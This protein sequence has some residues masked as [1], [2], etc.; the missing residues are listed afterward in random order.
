M[1]PLDTSQ[2]E[3]SRHLFELLRAGRQRSRQPGQR[4]LFGSRVALDWPHTLQG[5]HGE[6]FQ[7]RR[8]DHEESPF[9]SEVREGAEHLTRALTGMKSVSGRSYHRKAEPQS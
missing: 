4:K 2:E 1:G 8:G 7:F 6:Q 9:L 3:R 5:R